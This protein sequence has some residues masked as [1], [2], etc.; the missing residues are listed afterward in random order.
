MRKVTNDSIVAFNNN[1]EFKSINTSVVINDNGTF[2]SL[3]GNIIAGKDVKG[4]FINSCGWLSVTTKERLNG[5]IG[6]SI[7]QKNFGWFLNGNEWNG[8]KIYL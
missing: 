1:A 2:L 7:T 3:H 5:L 8:S 6:V 4:F